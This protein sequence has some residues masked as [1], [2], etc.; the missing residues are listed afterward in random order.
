[1]KR[2]LLIFTWALLLNGCVTGSQSCD[3]DASEVSASRQM[4]KSSTDRNGIIHNSDEVTKAL[5]PITDHMM[6]EKGFNGAIV[7]GPDSNAFVIFL[8]ETDN[9]LEEFQQDIEGRNSEFKKFQGQWHMSYLK[10]SQDKKPH[11]VRV[12]FDVEQF[13]EEDGET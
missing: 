11:Y 4:A 8:F 2:L 9:D 13:E 10:G 7:S 12:K 6:H 5:D 3:C 1:M